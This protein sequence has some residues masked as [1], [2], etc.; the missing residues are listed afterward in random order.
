LNPDQLKNY[1]LL[2]LP[3]I[4]ALSDTQC[5]QLQ[6]FVENGG[7][8]VATFETSL[9]DETGKPRKDFGLSELFG[10]SYAGSVE[11]PMKNSYLKFNTE[12]GSSS[13]HPVLKGL[14]NAFRMINGVWR[15][16]VTPQTTFPSPI[17][18][19]PTYPDLP[20]EHVYPRQPDTDIRELYLREM[21]KGRIAYIPWDIDRTFWNILN[22]DHG[23][24]LNNVFRW[25]LNEDS[26]VEVTGN[27]ILDILRPEP[28]R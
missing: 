22:V 5:K 10:V 27:G 18:L 28:P 19:I 1:K 26:I 14:E 20:M 25:A 2:V 17:T 8:I 7:S 11:G 16:N 13:Y 23:K 6:Q 4:A 21:G 15:L 3:N 12:A 9:Y 24:L